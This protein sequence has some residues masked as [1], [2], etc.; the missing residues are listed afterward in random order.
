[1]TENNT[2]RETHTERILPAKWSKGTEGPR[3]AKYVAWG[4][5]RTV[6]LNATP[7]PDIPKLVYNI[8]TGQPET[9]QK[10]L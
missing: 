7:D 1:M 2:T 10:T 3:K 8:G 6:V 5:G 4:G 9:L